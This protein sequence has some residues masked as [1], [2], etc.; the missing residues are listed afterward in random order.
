MDVDYGFPFSRLLQPRVFDESRRMR[1]E[2][3]LRLRWLNALTDA[4]V[5]SSK[6]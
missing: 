6:G 4:G 5:R 2:A 3:R 1:I